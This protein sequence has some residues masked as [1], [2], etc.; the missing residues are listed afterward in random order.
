MHVSE[1]RWVPWLLHKLTLVHEWH[2]RAPGNAEVSLWILMISALLVSSEHAAL[3]V[4]LLAVQ[5]VQQK[6]RLVRQRTNVMYSRPA[7]G[8]LLWFWVGRLATEPSLTAVTVDYV[9]DG[10]RVGSLHVCAYAVPEWAGLLR[11]LMLVWSLTCSMKPCCYL[12]DTFW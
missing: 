5:H 4:M 1:I 3:P 7:A 10:S 6:D 11:N 12:L 8:F 2:V 9:T